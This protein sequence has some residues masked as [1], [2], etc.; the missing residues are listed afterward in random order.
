MKLFT[1]R[2]QFLAHNL[3]IFDLEEGKTLV[4]EKQYSALSKLRQRTCDIGYED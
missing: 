4:D 3:Q 2:L 1:L